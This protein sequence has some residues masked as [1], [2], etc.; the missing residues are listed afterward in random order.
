MLEAVVLKLKIGYTFFKEYNRF[1]IQ[2]F[3]RQVSVWE[4]I[5]IRIMKSLKWI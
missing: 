4:A 1:L 2:R 5:S 3:K